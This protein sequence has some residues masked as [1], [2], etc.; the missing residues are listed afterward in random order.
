MLPWGGMNS[1]LQSEV[2]RR[3][4][5]LREATG[6]SQE[7]FARR[8]GF[9]RPFF[10]RIERGTQNI[11]IETLGRIAVALGVDMGRLVEGLPQQAKRTDGD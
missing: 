1:E 11:S 2:G 7:E 8:A 6:L 4:R 9:A 5:E 3:I 10:G